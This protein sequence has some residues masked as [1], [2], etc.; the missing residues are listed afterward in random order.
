MPHSFRVTFEIAEVIDIEQIRTGENQENLYSVSAEIYNTS[1]VQ[2]DVQVRPASIN[3]QTPPT[4]GEIILIFNGPNQYSGRNNVELQWYYLCTL[5]IQSS[6]Y[7]NVLP[8]TDKSNVN[9][10]ILP[11]KTINPLQAFSGDTLIQGRFGNSIRLGSSAI[12]KDVSQTSIMPSWFGNNSTNKLNSDPIIILSNTSKHSSNDQDPYGRKYSIENIDTDASSL[13]LTT[14]QQI[15]NLSL[16]K[17]TNKSGGY[18]NYNKSQVI[19][20]ADRILLSSK[21]NNIILDS[22][23]RISL[24]ADEI[25]LGSEDAAEPMVHGK[26]LVEI[27]TLI[28]NSIQAGSFGSGGIYS[29]PA[30]NPSLNQ[31]RQKLLKLTSTKYFM[32]K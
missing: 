12:Q 29:L 10:N 17:N 31:A 1:T 9:E 13:Y 3:M 30:D 2:H 20:T 32:K 14:T 19:G 24:N 6:I 16:N 15:N 27:L 5:P 8:T 7:K 21:T 22:S 18:L 11:T 25:L 4:V 28:M 23:N 26:E